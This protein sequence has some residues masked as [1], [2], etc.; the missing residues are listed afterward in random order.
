MIQK[1]RCVG[2]IT[3]AGEKLSAPAVLMAAGL[4]GR[5]LNAALRAH[6]VEYQLKGF[7]IG[8]RVEHPQA[9]MDQQQY[10]MKKRPD[11][12]GAAE[13]HLLSR[14][15]AGALPVCSFCMCPGG[16]VVMASGWQNHVVSNGMSC[17][18]R[19][20]EFANSA[21]IVT[22]SPD[23]FNSAE[24]AFAMLSGLEQSA[25]KLGGEDYTFPAQDIAAFLRGEKLLEN[26]KSSATTGL[27]AARLDEIFPRDWHDSIVPAVRYFDQQCPGFIRQGKFIGVETCV[28]SPVRF[29]R[30]QQTL[31]SSLPGLWLGGEGA[32][33]AGGIMSAAIDGL[34]LACAMIENKEGKL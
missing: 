32:G 3:T 31:A 20:G 17:H 8:S 9:F 10:H 14:G 26:R 24:E 33:C 29:V 12:L 11:S 18:A 5:E 28:S 15:E 2:V 23:K 22:L 16:E 19:A 25:F 7:Q 4:G 34:K 13:Y 21:L 6:K 30:N 27:K 1:N